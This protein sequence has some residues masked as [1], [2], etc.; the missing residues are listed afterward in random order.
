[1]EPVVIIP[2]LNPDIKLVLVS[3]KLQK[4]GLKAVVVN[5]GSKRSVMVFSKY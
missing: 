5:D 2:A 3:K 1:M 4:V